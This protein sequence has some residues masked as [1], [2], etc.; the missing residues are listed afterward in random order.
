M[1]NDDNDDSA[2]AMSDD[3]SV[4]S[5]T[6]LTRRIKFSLET[7]F[8][9]VWVRGELSNVKHHT[10]GHL[11]FTIKDEGAQ[12]SAVLWRS[13]KGAL[14]F[15]P[16]D[17]M[18][19]QARGSLTVYPPRGNYQID[20]EQLQ[21]MGIG[22][23]QRAFELLKRKLD[24]EGLFDAERKKPLPE[25]PSCIGIVTSETGAA[26]Q[27]M[28]SVL[29]RRMPSV[30]VILAP[31]R[32]QGE[33]AAE[34]I[35]EAIRTL[36]RLGGIDVMIVGRGGGSLEDLWPFNEETVARE[37]AASRIP[38]VSAV[39]HEI[40][41]SIADFVADL[42][43]PTPSAAAEL[44]VRDRTEILEN[45]RSMC[46]TVQESVTTRVEMLR[47]RVRS[48][49]GSYSFNRPRD[50]LRE[51]VQRLDE[52]DR[53]LS[54]S[55]SRLQETVHQRHDSLGHRLEALSPRNVLA[56]GYA[57]VHMD[58]RVISQAARLQS[59]DRTTIEFADGIVPATIEGKGRS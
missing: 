35:A 43:A 14:S 39:G 33:G 26:L 17:G 4:L 52:L 12:L 21:P 56:R 47:E 30:E 9:R 37:I 3:V 46:Y 32:V 45:L 13:R 7:T 19:V 51:F 44:V 50:V 1:Q 38:V 15:I 22:E 55:F 29:A 28:R 59:G 25:F 6:E 41:F 27:D 58:G 10:S 11:Y 34:E 31:V 53:G 5:V 48:L 24:A 20:V 18:K 8:P 2:A 16:A 36:N 57:M 49:T 23:L 42:R 40:D 54:R